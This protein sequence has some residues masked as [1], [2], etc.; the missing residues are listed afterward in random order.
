MPRRIFLELSMQ[1]NMQT[2][3][4]DVTLTIPVPFLVI[5]ENE[6]PAFECPEIIQFNLENKTNVE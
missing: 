4:R 2:F 5:Y 6:K 1:S 3:Y